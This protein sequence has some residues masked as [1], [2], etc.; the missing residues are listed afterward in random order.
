[1]KQFPPIVLFFVLLWSCTENTA[2]PKQQ[3]PIEMR[4]NNAIEKSQ[5][6]TEEERLKQS[7]LA[8]SIAKRT[9]IDSLVYKALYNKIQ[10]DL[11]FQHFDST[12]YYLDE[13]KN[14]S[15]TVS[16]K[17]GYHYLKGLSFNGKHVDSSFGHY[18]KSQ[19]LYASV[20]DDARAGYSLLLMAEIQRASADYPGAESTMT[21]AY[22]HLKN[23]ELY[24]AHISNM[25][26]LIY[27]E[28]FNYEKAQLSYQKAYG[29]TAANESEKKA[30]IKNNIAL[31]YIEKKDYVTSIAILD[32]LAN[33][34]SL[35]LGTVIKAKVLSN[36]GYAIFLSKK[37]DGIAYLN[38]A[39]A[40]Y[41]TI[42]D[43]FGKLANYLKFAEIYLDKN[44]ILSKSYAAKAYHL[45]KL[46]HNGDDRLSA[47]ELLAKVAESK[48]ESDKIFS[49]YVALNDSITTSRQT[50]KNQFAKIR[51]D[52]S[53]A[54]KSALISKAESAQSRL[55]AERTQSRN[56]MLLGLV[57]LLI[58]GF[59]YWYYWMKKKSILD[60]LKASY[61]AEIRISRKVHDE[62]ANDIY[63]AILFTET[64]DISLEEKKQ[65]LLGDLDSVYKRT[66]DI[67]KENAS[68]ETGE[69]FPL[70]L[71]G[72]LSEY[73][74]GEVNVVR[75]GIKEIV[76]DKIDTIKKITVY[77][78]LQE[79]MVN[80]S[81]HSH[82]NVCLVNFKNVGK[83][84]EVL[85][86]DNGVGMGDQ[87]IIFKNGLANAENRIHGIGGSLTFDLNPEKGVKIV[88]IF[89]A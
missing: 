10:N 58:S 4:V 46:L 29:L 49:E 39:D 85:Y 8:F 74:N 7:N 89:P 44:K 75:S 77:R 30:V 48:Q 63:N 79:M 82:A 24:Q 69:N 66:R 2:K 65:R 18:E 88:I 3:N 34:P 32:S 15:N 42:D 9:R 17:A 13:L 83:N 20:R 41:D 81:K 51:Y 27:K 19:K 12:A 45:S 87:K 67:S 21:D 1:M 78:V 33:D 50:A 76:W 47:L 43:A 52:S 54:E 56:F 16:Y 37:G 80:M 11:S 6:G 23:H 61:S 28:L 36:L 40:I 60:R 14:R 26:G 25:F 31:I 73:Q 84:I 5:Q 70:H 62:L 35:N 57:V 72:M 53:E 55:E 86:S 68:I 71:L 38:E 59:T 64:Q 22:Q